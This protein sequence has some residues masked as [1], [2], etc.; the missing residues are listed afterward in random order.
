VV[1]DD[2]TSDPGHQQIRSSD[3]IL[4][5]IGPVPVAVLN[6]V[7]GY[8]RSHPDWTAEDLHDAIRSDTGQAVPLDALY[9]AMRIHN[10]NER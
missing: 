2:D 10:F 1:H 8:A 9:A 5:N 6:L 7:A 4:N 3:R